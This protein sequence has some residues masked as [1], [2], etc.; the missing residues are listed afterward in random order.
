M[1]YES[2]LST[3]S[4]VIRINW[5]FDSI[6]K[7]SYFVR[8]S[9]YIECSVNLSECYNILEL[10]FDSLILIKQNNAISALKPSE[11]TWKVTI[12]K[13][14]TKAVIPNIYRKWKSRK[15]GLGNVEHVVALA[16]LVM[17]IF[18]VWVCYG[19]WIKIGTFVS[20]NSRLCFPMA[21]SKPRMETKRYVNRLMKNISQWI[22]N[23]V[24]PFLEVHD[25]D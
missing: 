15:S 5:L 21:P 3:I 13:Q 4:R 10:P 8:C 11:K 23:G 14:N 22:V 25:K 9:V 7:L 2:D 20:V 17:K 6:F 19:N 1:F 18:L 16:Y 24:M 12:L